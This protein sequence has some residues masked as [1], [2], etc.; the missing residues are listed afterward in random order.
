MPLLSPSPPLHPLATQL[1]LLPSSLPDTLFQP[2]LP[3]T[4]YQH[5]LA[6]V[7][8]QTARDLIH[9]TP[10]RRITAHGAYVAH[11]FRVTLLRTLVRL[12]VIQ[13]SPFTSR[14]TLP[15]LQSK[16]YIT[17][18]Y[19]EPGTKRYKQV[20]P[21]HGSGASQTTAA[22]KRWTKRRDDDYNNGSGER[23][24]YRNIE[25]YRY[26]EIKDLR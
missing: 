6:Q 24:Y 15:D 8:L 11:R 13:K 9:K 14:Q 20:S 12:R 23:M 7:P 4:H 10:Y 18:S 22:Y 17:R 16:D 1:W 25:C 3:T 26:R 19:Y 5:A 21:F 2:L